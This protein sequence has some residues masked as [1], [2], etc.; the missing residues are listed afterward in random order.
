MEPSFKAIADLFAVP[1]GE[2]LEIARSKRKKEGVT[3]DESDELGRQ[4]LNDGDYELAIK[5]FRRAVE[6]REPGDISSR[7]DLAGA[8]DYSDQ[9]PQALR[10][11]D[12]ALRARQDAAEPRVGIS[13]LYKRY[14][15]F[16]ESIQK[17]EEAI[18]LEPANAYYHLKLA[19][20]LRDAGEPTRAVS[21]VQGAITAQPDDPFYHYWL[22][23][24]L[25]QLRRFSEALDSLRAAIELSPG[26]DYLYLRAAVA[27]W[28]AERRAEAIKAVR[29]ASDLDPNKHVYHGILGIMLAQ[30]GQTEEAN[31][32][33]TRSSKM[34]R[35][36]RDTLTRIAAE[37][38]INLTSD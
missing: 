6:Q 18:R 9:D 32:E 34:D 30:E 25:I 13:D 11:Y 21:A 26:D 16:R 2:D 8:Y 5:H 1:T 10:Q 38:G 28:G 20:T 35:Y 36:D 7:I 24:L 14:G 19:E 29:L 15:R 17:L 3:A 22:G 37:L 4:S 23:D 33:E 27:F 31:L 12:L